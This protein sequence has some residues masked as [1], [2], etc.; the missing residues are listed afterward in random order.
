[1]RSLHP[2]DPPPVSVGIRFYN[3]TFFGVENNGLVD[4]KTGFT[5]YD[6]KT[7]RGQKPSSDTLAAVKDRLNTYAGTLLKLRQ[8]YD[9]NLFKTDDRCFY[10]MGTRH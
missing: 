3:N 5:T 7:F 10:T 8:Y 6:F 1:L 9:G 2:N 4:P